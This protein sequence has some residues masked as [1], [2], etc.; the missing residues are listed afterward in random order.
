MARIESSRTFFSD[1]PFVIFPFEVI[2][3]RV[4]L[5][6][7][8]DR[9]EKSTDQVIKPINVDALGKWK[10]KIPENV[11]KNLDEIA[12]MLRKLGYDPNRGPEQYGVPD[13]LVRKKEEELKK[14]AEVYIAKEEEIKKERQKITEILSKAKQ[15]KLAKQAKADPLQTS[16]GNE[17]LNNNDILPP[18]AGYGDSSQQQPVAAYNSLLNQVPAGKTAPNGKETGKENGDNLSASLNYNNLAEA[19]NLDELSSIRNK[20]KRLASG[21]GRASEVAGNRPEMGDRFEKRPEHRD[22][23]AADDILPLNSIHNNLSSAKTKSFNADRL[24]LI[25]FKEKRRKFLQ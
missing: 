19:L 17:N 15:A 23:S 24:K 8:P 10:G 16:T 6:S 13:E 9:L 18:G 25:R 4:S 3:I 1:S 14:N 21:Y 20:V 7:L 12:P 22:N 2:L 5:P 11:E